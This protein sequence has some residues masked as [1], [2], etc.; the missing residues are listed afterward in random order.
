MKK[1]I[2]SLLTLALVTSISSSALATE[3]IKETEVKP[4]A[5]IFYDRE[6]NDT[7]EQANP[8]MIGGQINGKLAWSLEGPD[9]NRDW[10]TFTPTRSGKVSLVFAYS[11]GYKNVLRVE[12]RDEGKRGPTRMKW[13]EEPGE[14]LQFDV[15][16][17]EKYYIC[18]EFSQANAHLKH[19]YNVYT[20]YIN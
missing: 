6:P 15:K 10:Y 3:K 1:V 12:V 4:L 19:D 20:E 8:Y 17:G 2:F 13:T 5:A 7:W 9:D 18:V 14:V 11:K 16:E